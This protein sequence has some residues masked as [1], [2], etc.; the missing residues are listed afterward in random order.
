M[1]QSTSLSKTTMIYA[2]RTHTIAT[3]VL[4][5]QFRKIKVLLNYQNSNRNLKM[6]INKFDNR[7]MM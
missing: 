1:Q 3:E 2:I 6:S 5:E 4:Q 7:S